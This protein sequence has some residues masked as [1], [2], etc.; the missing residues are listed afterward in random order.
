MKIQFLG[1]GSAFVMMEE[2]YQSNILIT[3]EVDEQQYSSSENNTVL[4]GTDKVTKRLLFDAGTHISESLNSQGLVPTDIDVI[5]LSHLHSD[6]C[7]GLE[8]IGFKTYFIPEFGTNKPI[9]IANNQVIDMLWENVLKGTMQYV[10]GG[11]LTIDDYFQTTRL[12]P[13]GSFQ[14]ANTEMNLVQVPHVISDK[15]EVPSYGM[16]FEEDGVKIFITGDT[17]AAFWRTIGFYEM[18]EWVFHDCEFADY[19]N[20]VHAQFHQLKEYPDNYRNKTWLYHYMLGNKTFEE[21]ESEV[22]EAGFAGLVKR[23][24]IFDT[25]DK[26]TFDFNL[27]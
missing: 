22:L 14:F 2:N 26:S 1:S 7:G 5:V 18:D 20:S 6:H 24:Q 19:P 4:L 13:R 21:L 9:L 27:K 3:K 25:Q 10:N 23:G 16:R 15:I 8:Y 11:T 12:Q 17:Q